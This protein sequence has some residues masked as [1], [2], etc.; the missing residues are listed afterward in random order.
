MKLILSIIC[1]SLFSLPSLA[2]IVAEGWYKVLSANVHV[3]YYVS[4]FEYDAKKREFI[5]KSFLKT[6]AAGGDITESM[7]VYSDEGMNPIK[8]TYTSI[9]GGQTTTIDAA[10]KK[11]VLVAVKEVSSLSAPA[12]KKSPTASTGSTTSTTKTTIETKLEKGTF[13]SSHL[14]LLMLKKGLKVGVNFE[15]K[16]VAEEDAKIYT[17]RSLIKE[18]KKAGQKD[19]F[20]ILNDYKSVKYVSLM[21]T[22]GQLVAT[23]APTLGLITNLQATQKEATGNIPVPLKSLKK[24]FGK[25][26]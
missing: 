22:S 17:G 25:L 1:L 19:L 26:P 4:R 7:E 14:A 9:V 12:A 10:V 5:S 6:N 21:D 16:A 13:F 11:N 23:K 15:Y 8:Y 24:I 20:R 18:I 3:G 2:D